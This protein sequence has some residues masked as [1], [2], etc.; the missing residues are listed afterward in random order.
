MFYIHMTLKLFV[1]MFP[2]IN[3]N[4]PLIQWKLQVLVI[5]ESILVNQ[6]NKNQYSIPTHVGGNS[7]QRMG[8][9]PLAQ[10]MHLL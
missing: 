4:I 10:P 5:P 9:P 1:E 6:W 3:G 8:S 7:H 2:C